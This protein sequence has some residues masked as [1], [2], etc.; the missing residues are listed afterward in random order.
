ML[1]FPICHPVCL[2][3]RDRPMPMDHFDVELVGGPLDGRHFIE[4][5]GRRFDH[6]PHSVYVFAGAEYSPSH[7]DGTRLKLRYVGQ[8]K[9]EL[10]GKHQ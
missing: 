3:L 6:N 9:P 10:N 5:G 4:D 8:H 2:P 1:T 7:L